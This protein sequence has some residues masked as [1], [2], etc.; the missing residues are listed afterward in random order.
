MTEIDIDEMTS[1]ELEELV[2]GKVLKGEEVGLC[3]SCES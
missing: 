2:R 3:E 1:E